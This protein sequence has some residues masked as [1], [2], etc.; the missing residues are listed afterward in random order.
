MLLSGIYS[1]I[2]EMWEGGVREE[3]LYHTWYPDDLQ[4]KLLMLLLFLLIGF[5]FVLFQGKKIR[6]Y[7]YN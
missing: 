2:H 3:Q 5:T 1:W 7:E 4:T 6:I